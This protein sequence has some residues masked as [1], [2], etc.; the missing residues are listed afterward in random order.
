MDYKVE[1][2]RLAVSW[3]KKLRDRLRTEGKEEDSQ[4]VNDLLVLARFDLKR[5]EE[6]ARRPKKKAAE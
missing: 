3:G 6:E 1:M 5:R 2:A 4:V